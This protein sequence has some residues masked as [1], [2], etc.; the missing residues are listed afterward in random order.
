MNKSCPHILQLLNRKAA[1]NLPAGIVEFISGEW[2]LEGERL[3]K[4]A[5]ARIASLIASTSEKIVGDA[6]RSDLSGVGTEHKLAELL[7]E[8]TLAD[9]LVRISDGKPDFHPQNVLGKYCDVKVVFDGGDV[10]GEVKRLADTWEGG[11]RSLAKSI[12][13]P[14]PSNVNRPRAM[15]LYEKLKGV[16]AQ[17]PL[18]ALNIL[19]LFQ[20]SVW[21]GSV[22]I[23]QALFGDASALTE[24]T[25]MTVHDDG[26]FAL[27]EW[28]NVTAC[29]HSRVNADGTLSI[30]QIWSNPKANVTL[31][32]NVRERLALAV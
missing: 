4:L 12:T 25:E 14:K 7:C 15:D 16:H 11:V 18:G 31:V 6:Y 2:G 10:Y 30:V 8:I 27:D 26:L 1:L 20:P 32:D 23:K 13:A 19:F 21:N 28:R 3:L 17:F 29:A 9:A 24:S 22:Y 5:D